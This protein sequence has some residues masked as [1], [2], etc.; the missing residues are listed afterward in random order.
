MRLIDVLIHH[1]LLQETRHCLCYSKYVYENT[2][3][4]WICLFKWNCCQPNKI[5]DPRQY[6]I[7]RPSLI[8]HPHA[9]PFFRIPRF[10]EYNTYTLSNVME[11]RSIHCEHRWLFR[12][13][14]SSQLHPSYI[15][16][17]LIN[18]QRLKYLEFLLNNVTE[19]RKPFY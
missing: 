5:E 15:K 11:L 2:K 4:K 1:I 9:L 13:W 12:Q 8:W 7:D 16:K 14:P 17:N 3:L 6:L 19:R 18:S 10:K